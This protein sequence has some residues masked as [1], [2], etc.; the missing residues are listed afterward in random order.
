MA[1]AWV[2]RE[3]DAFDML[4]ARP[5]PCPATPDPA[6]C[7]RGIH[8]GTLAHGDP[9]NQSLFSTP[10]R[11]SN[12]VSSRALFCDFDQM[13]RID[14]YSGDPGA[15]PNPRPDPAGGDM[16]ACAEMPSA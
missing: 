8:G 9:R 15:V 7:G 12:S 5:S 13:S 14:F 4:A 2:R 10:L 1:H 11:L 16:E 6:P 3:T